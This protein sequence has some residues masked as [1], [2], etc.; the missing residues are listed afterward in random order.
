MLRQQLTLQNF[1]QRPEKRTNFHN[2]DKSGEEDKESSADA[3]R[4]GELERGAS[5][6]AT[7][8]LQL[9]RLMRLGSTS[10]SASPPISFASEQQRLPRLELDGFTFAALARLGDLPRRERGDDEVGQGRDKTSFSS[11][12][13]ATESNL[14]LRR[15]PPRPLVSVPRL[16]QRCK[17]T[18]LANQHPNKL[19]QQPQRQ[20]QPNQQRIKKKKQHAR[21]ALLPPPLLRVF[22]GA[23][24][25]SPEAG[26]ALVAEV[27]HLLVTSCAAQTPLS[28]SSS[29]KSPPSSYSSL[30]STSDCNALIG[31]LAGPSPL[32][33]S[34]SLPEATEYGGEEILLGAASS[35]DQLLFT[36][37]RSL[38]S[39]Q[40]KETMSTNLFDGSTWDGLSSSLE[41]ALSL[42]TSLFCTTHQQE[43]EQHVVAS[44]LGSTGGASAVGSGIS[45]G[46]GFSSGL[47]ASLR[48]FLL[49]RT[50][51][52]VSDKKLWCCCC[53]CRCRCR[54]LTS[55]M[56]QLVFDRVQCCTFIPF[57]RV[58]VSLF[59]CTFISDQAA[60]LFFFRRVISSIFVLP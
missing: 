16:W 29:S 27:F 6:A 46:S 7:Q 42:P 17:K 41:A 39:V 18:L 19:N 37:T 34:L 4:V 8:A 10:T 50:N 1:P 31:A 2:E 48:V 25:R 43:Q 53:C 5:A 59:L 47:E 52:K 22:L 36:F 54:R 9:Y 51:A 26:P 21:H 35:L 56:C 13:A 28:S 40:N 57:L 45:S 55:E 3:A 14:R 15:R 44:T 32:L 30:L 11:S 60:A 49:M 38:E 12:S 58:D 23:L 24:G 33:S 20:T